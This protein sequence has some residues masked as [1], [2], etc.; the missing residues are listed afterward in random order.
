MSGG[1][2]RTRGARFRRRVGRVRVRGVGKRSVHRAL[3]DVTAGGIGGELRRAGVAFVRHRSCVLCRHRLR[4]RS[5]RA[6]PVRVHLAP[7]VR[8]PTSPPLLALFLSIFRAIPI[9]PYTSCFAFGIGDSVFIPPVHP[10][11]SSI[12]HPSRRS[13]SALASSISSSRLVSTF[14]GCYNMLYNPSFARYRLLT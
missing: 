5:R 6:F 12:S 3:R 14:R 13:I 10:L 7:C 8:H 9:Q 4:S 1:V 2:M 11:I